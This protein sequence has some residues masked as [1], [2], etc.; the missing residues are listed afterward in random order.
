MKKILVIVLI[1]LVGAI[2]WGLRHRVPLEEPVPKESFSSS[3]ET[4]LTDSNRRASLRANGAASR[5]VE[6][7]SQITL[8]IERLRKALHGGTDEEIE[9]AL[10]ALAQLLQND[11]G[12]HEVWASFEAE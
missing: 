9:A 4:G 1:C 8:A 12:V 5:P 2:Y 3:N 11:P 6:E 7:G 10:E